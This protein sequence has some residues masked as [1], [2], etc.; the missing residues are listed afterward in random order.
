MQSLATVGVDLRRCSRPSGQV[1]KCDCDA[2]DASVHQVRLPGQLPARFRALPWVSVDYALPRVASP[3][4]PC[5]TGAMETC[6]VRNKTGGS[7]PAVLACLR[8]AR[9][10]PRII[11]LTAGLSAMVT[12]GQLGTCGSIRS[13]PSP[14]MQPGTG[15]SL[16]V[17][18]VRCWRSSSPATAR[19]GRQSSTLT[20]CGTSSSR[21]WT[22]Q[23]R[24]GG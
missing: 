5:D 21:R 19:N 3:G 18:A 13:R 6:L 16:A 1:S 7:C 11:M 22:G 17:E 4:R 23:Y 15:C 2:P 14:V 10:G 9:T 20:S 12:Y 24:D 8:S